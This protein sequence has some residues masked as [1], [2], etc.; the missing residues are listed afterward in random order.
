[1]L[2]INIGPRRLIEQ[3]EEN[4]L[5]SYSNTVITRHSNGKKQTMKMLLKHVLQTSVSRWHM[6]IQ[7][8]FS[9]FQSV[10][11]SHLAQKTAACPM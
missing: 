11:T 8:L 2:C 4:T 5:S 6:F 1:M 7:I 10:V 9:F 3:G